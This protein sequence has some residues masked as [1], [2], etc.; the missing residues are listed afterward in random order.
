MVPPS[1]AAVC[2]GI[3]DIPAPVLAGEPETASGTRVAAAVS[4]AATVAIVKVAFI[5]EF[6]LTV[7]TDLSRA[8]LEAVTTVQFVC[9]SGKPVCPAG[10]PIAS[11]ED[12]FCVKVPTE[13]NDLADVTSLSR[14]QIDTDVVSGSVGDERNPASKRVLFPDP[15]W[16][17]AVHELFQSLVG[18]CCRICVNLSPKLPFVVH[19]LKRQQAKAKEEAVCATGSALGFLAVAHEV[20]VPEDLRERKAELH[21]DVGEVGGEDAVV[22]GV[23]EFWVLTGEPCPYPGPSILEGRM[24]NRRICV[25]VECMRRV[26]RMKRMSR[27]L[28]YEQNEP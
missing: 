22:E 8:K 23:S 3:H 12:D 24:E 21:L 4:V 26:K 1:E 15:I 17:D 16:R 28:S 18:P 19:I 11:P 6:I 25:W 2:P 20:G 14:V 10:R 7:I 9:K 27:G 5:S 13:D